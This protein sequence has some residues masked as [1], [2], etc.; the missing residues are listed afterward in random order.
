MIAFTISSR[1]FYGYTQTLHDSFR[2]FHPDVPFHAVLADDLTDFDADAFP[3]EVLSPDTLGVPGFETMAERY[4]ITELNTALKPFAFLYLFD[5]HP[6]ETVLYLDPDI[7]VLSR[8]VELLDLVSQGTE[9]VLTPHLTEPSEYADFRDQHALRYGINNLGFC[10]LRD[11]PAVRRAVW[12][13]ARRLEF[14][15]T[16]D[17]ENGLF[18]DQKWADLLPAFIERSR[19][20]RHPGYNVGHW[21]LAQRRVARV[22]GSWHV[23]GQPLR[24]VHFSGNKIEDEGVF[25]RHNEQFLI[26]NI[27]PLR[28]LL[29]DYRARVSSRGHRYFTTIPYAFSWAGVAGLNRHTPSAVETERRRAGRTPV[30]YLPVMRWSSQDDYQAWQR[31]SGTVSSRRRAAE[32]LDIPAAEVF[33]LAGFCAVCEEPSKFRAGPMYSSGRLSDGR[34]IPMWREHLDCLGCRLV[35]RLRGAYHIFRQELG[36]TQDSRIHVTEQA[37]P[38]FA[39]LSQRFPN[40]VGGQYI[41]A[42]QSGARVASIQHEDAQAPSFPTEGFEYVLS[43]DVLGHVPFYLKALSEFHRTLRGGGSILLTAPFSLDQAEHQV[44]VT[45]DANGAITHLR[46]PEYHGNPIGTAGSLSFRMF[47][48][49][50]LNELRDVGFERPE[51]VTYWS[52]QLRYYGEPSVAVTARKPG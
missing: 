18:V 26:H 16:I 49:Q 7:L 22:D 1:N 42:S 52:R 48:W 43:F 35:T 20:L 37:T 11:T 29:D 8:F 10:T 15:C 45:T 51:V 17:L 24:F 25:S 28:E 38:L 14:Q 33:T 41:G 47:G 23:N 44:M 19:L 2:R 13:W 3:F 21:N 9:C 27:G 34:V 4:N 39:A 30:P 36:P 31:V 50:L 12:W 6:G 5:R 40:T 32:E 46:P